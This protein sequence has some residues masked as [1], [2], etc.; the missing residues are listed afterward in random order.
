MVE[1]A[2]QC[3]QLFIVRV[4]ELG[5]LPH[6]VTLNVLTIWNA[7]IL[8][9]VA[10][11]LILRLLV[12]VFIVVATLVKERWV[13]VVEN[14]LGVGANFPERVDKPLRCLVHLRICVIQV[15]LT[16]HIRVARA[17][18]DMLLFLLISFL[19]NIDAKLC[20]GVLNVALR[21]EFIVFSGLILVLP[22]T[23]MMLLFHVG[24]RFNRIGC[25]HLAG[26]EIICLLDLGREGAPLAEQT[27]HILHSMV[28]VE[29]G[30]HCIQQVL[31]AVQVFLLLNQLQLKSGPD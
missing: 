4:V 7:I 31:V 5:K 18:A 29:Q 6:S 10:L 23:L 3:D 2:T 21:D 30:C 24:R 25:L 9:L 1:G 16:L 26:L 27:S 19:I 28:R 13:R 22:R 14:V 11:T 8:V 12:I 15:G 20:I 17:Q